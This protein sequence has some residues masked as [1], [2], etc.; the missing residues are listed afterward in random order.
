MRRVVPLLFVLSLGFAPAPVYREKP[1]ANDNEMKKLQGDW[2]LIVGTRGG[3]PL[4]P[5]QITGVRLGAGRLELFGNGLGAWTMSVDSS[6]TSK[7]FKAVNRGEVIE[8]TYSLD[9][10]RLTVS[11]RSN[12]W[13]TVKLNG[14]GS[15]APPDTVL[16]LT[17]SKG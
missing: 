10:D 6:K 5:G 13:I 12:Y 2:K 1:S 14:I 11:Y 9:G 17:R 15:D 7:R 4:P 3:L 16:I 8:G